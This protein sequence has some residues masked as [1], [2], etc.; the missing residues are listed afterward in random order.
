MNLPAPARDSRQGSGLP[1]VSTRRKPGRALRW[2]ACCS[3]GQEFALTQHKEIE[4]RETH[5]ATCSGT[6][7]VVLWG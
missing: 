3:C 7:T 6:T 1:A 2:Q 5:E 4:W